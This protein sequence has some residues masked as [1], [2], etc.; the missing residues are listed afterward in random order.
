MY[1]NRTWGGSLEEDD[2]GTLPCRD[3]PR[4]TLFCCCIIVLFT[5]AISLERMSIN[6]LCD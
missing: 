3:I 4:D 1:S 2:D 5:V 6:F